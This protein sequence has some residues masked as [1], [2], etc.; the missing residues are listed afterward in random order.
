MESESNN[1]RYFVMNIS[2]FF[3]FIVNDKWSASG[4]I[5]CI[6][7]FYTQFLMSFEVLNHA[8]GIATGIVGLCVA[9]LSFYKLSIQ[10]AKEKRQFDKM[11]D[12]REQEE[13]NEPEQK[14][15]FN[16]K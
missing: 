11:S 3:H 9:I 8:I 5:S 16:G 14:I 2:N 6:A 12:D 7:G 13:F 10:V 15:T 4:V 1:S